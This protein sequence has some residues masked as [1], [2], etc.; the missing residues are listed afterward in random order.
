MPFW[1]DRPHWYHYLCS[2]NT[3]TRVSLFSAG[4]FI[5]LGWY[6]SFFVIPLQT[7]LSHA[8]HECVLLEQEHASFQAQVKKITQQQQ[9]HDQL[10]AVYEQATPLSTLEHSPCKQLLEQL[11]E[12]HI[13]C[14]SIK[15]LNQKKTVAG[16]ISEY[17][18]CIR[19]TFHSLL[20]WLADSEQQML[21]LRVKTM[22][23][24]STNH[25]KLEVKLV[26]Q[27]LSKALNN[28]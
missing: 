10:I 22:Q 25:N 3:V 17:M 27:M 7:K 13:K 15:P 28:D 16:T 1:K 20:E 4:L 11:H 12:Q 2:L 14:M 19:T 18:L 24:D 8:R 6:A 23:I 9:L 21:P 26:V 5:G